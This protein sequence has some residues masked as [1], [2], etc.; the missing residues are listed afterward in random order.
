[1]NEQ[2]LEAAAKAIARVELQRSFPSLKGRRLDQAVEIDANWMPYIEQT[3]AAIAI[4][5]DAEVARLAAENAALQ[6]ANSNARSAIAIWQQTDKETRAKLEAAERDEERLID[7]R[8]A[9]EDAIQEIHVALGGNGQ[10]VGRLPPEEPPNSGDL[11]LD[12]L[13]LAKAAARD[14]ERLNALEQMLIH[15]EETHV[16][17]CVKESADCDA[18][19]HPHFEIYG[20]D[21]KQPVYAKTLRDAIDAARK[22]W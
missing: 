4:Y 10:W 9:A 1:M 2:A 17:F 13:E 22:E 16:S 12:A 21:M 3:R 19:D 8:D 5:H 15:G 20:W 11:K 6:A 18:D 7:Q 14:T